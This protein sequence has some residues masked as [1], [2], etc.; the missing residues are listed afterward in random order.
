MRTIACLVLSHFIGPCNVKYGT[1]PCNV[2]YL[3]L[4]VFVSIIQ[5]DQRAENAYISSFLTKVKRN[6]DDRATYNT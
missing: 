4:I 5:N 1:V 6:V 2:Q 3:T